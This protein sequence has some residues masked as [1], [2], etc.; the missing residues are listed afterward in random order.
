MVYTVTTE[1][2]VPGPVIYVEFNDVITNLRF[3][4]GTLIKS[5][6]LAGVELATIAPTAFKAVDFAYLSVISNNPELVASSLPYFGLGAHSNLSQ[7][8]ITIGGNPMN[9]RIISEC[10]I[11]VTSDSDSFSFAAKFGANFQANDVLRFKIHT[12]FFP[13]YQ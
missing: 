8:F 1:Y 3:G 12:V 4:K 10:D 2:T 6:E 7:R 13:N 9:K 11:F 5:I